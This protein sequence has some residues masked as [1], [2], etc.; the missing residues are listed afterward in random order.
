MAQK[1]SH[2]NV[3]MSCK[4]WKELRYIL[5][6]STKQQHRAENARY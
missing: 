4:A 3:I 5:N 1:S 2:N 6:N